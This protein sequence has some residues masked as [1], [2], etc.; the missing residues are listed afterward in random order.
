MTGF[1]ERLQAFLRGKSEQA[2]VKHPR[3]SSVPGSA[4]RP[5]LSSSLFAAQSS[6]Q[7]VGNSSP[8]SEAI[9]SDTPAATPGDASP[10]PTS[11]PKAPTPRPKVR[12]GRR[13][14]RSLRPLYQSW[15]AWTVLAAI[16]GTTGVLG[17][18]YYTIQQM[19][20]DLP[21]PEDALT[22]TR[23]GTLTIEA[24]DGTILQQLGPA[25]RESL[26][27]DDIPIEVK[28]AFLASEDNDFYEHE[29]V[30]YRAI[31]RA[32]LA[33]VRAGEVVEG[34]STITQQLAR[35][36]FLDQDQTL[37]RKLREALLAQKMEQELTKDQIFERYINLV[38][39]GGG[40]YGI[41]D[42]AWVYFSKSVDELTLSEIA[43]IVGLAPAPSE[44]SPLVN[45]DVA[46]RRRNLVLERMEEAGY[47]TSQ[48]RQ[49]AAATE[50][51]LTPSDPRNLYSRFPYFTQYVRQQL[52][53][54]IDPQDVEIGGLTIETTLNPQMQELARQTVN[55]AIADY[56]PG[57][58]FTQAALVA[59]DPRNGYIH[60]M[61]GGND[62]NESQFNR[63]VQAQR[64]PGSTFKTFIYA[65]AIAGGFSPYK[66]YLDAKLVVDGYEPKNYGENYSGNQSMRDALIRSVNIIAVKVLI[67][68]GFD[69][70]IEMAERMGIR[71][72][73][74]PAYSLA[75]GSVEVNLLELTGA[76]GTLATSGTHI[77]PHG[78]TR[79]LNR[80]GEVIYEA[81]FAAEQS[82]DED[83]A[84]IM[85]WMLRGVV[86]S[87][88]GGN[89]SLGNRPV[90]GKTGTSENRRDLWFIGY[91]P[92]MVTGVWLGND[93]NTPTRG[94][95]STAAR[96]WRNFM[97][98]AVEGMPVES[99][100]ELPQLRGREATIELQR[101]RP[102][103]IQEA[104]GP[105]DD[106]SEERAS[107]PSQEAA[108][109]SSTNRSTSS[110]RQETPN[111]TSRSSP[112]E[113][114]EPVPSRFERPADI[115]PR[116]EP[117]ARP[118][119][120]AAPPPPAEPAEPVAPA[121]EPEPVAPV[122]AAP[123]PAPDPPPAP[124]PAPAPEPPP[125]VDAE[126]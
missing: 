126:E 49:A 63:V 90:A 15:F 122:D 45:E 7:T 46:L 87:G 21:D 104:R 57:Q 94:A 48:E 55:Q 116:A 125:A 28:E 65:T 66:S 39:L 101:V 124:A 41:A 95:S 88:T 106:D 3:S 56:G 70:A 22:Y 40:A 23:D 77:E 30:A 62:F 111:R 4:S 108:E 99:F 117:V 103:R 14:P 35:I 100:P 43:M 18:S 26:T 29:G 97:N 19:R 54:L 33:N 20:A 118:Q 75:L 120:P 44:F 9:A 119:A 69:P 61:V 27:W 83:S 79:I 6:P 32:A 96:V 58:R 17:A 84:D 123:A 85:T 89:A 10:T 2:M 1:R 13:Q 60:A 31:A 47:I 72:P 80:R 82:I 59:I 68:V 37:E 105:G 50:L 109:E 11:I 73:L 5:S 121:P 53:L 81:D 51:T 76:Y 102:G 67:D 71:S 12:L 34:A 38:Y 42:A 36:V 92:Q 112:P 64:Q 98:P 8:S 110:D 52:P 86:T 115:E 107:E 16:F 25:T 93:D 74:I 91:V 78:I 24:V 113:S 114:P